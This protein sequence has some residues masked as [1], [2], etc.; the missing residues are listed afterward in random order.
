MTKKKLDIDLLICNTLDFDTAYKTMEYNS[1]FFDFNKK[2]ILSNKDINIYGLYP[3]LNNWGNINLNKE[4]KI[5]VNK[6]L[7]IINFP[8]LKTS[9]KIFIN[10]K[11]K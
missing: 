8:K 7:K 11:F 9:L 3:Y 5:V 4:I 6:F 10:D 2:I 1:K